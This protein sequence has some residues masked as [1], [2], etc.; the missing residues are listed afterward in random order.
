[1]ACDHARKDCTAQ[2]WTGIGI[3]AASGALAGL[4]LG[5][6]LIAGAFASAA[7]GAVASVANGAATAAQDGRKYSGR[8]ALND[9]VTSGLFGMVGFG[10]GKAVSVA[11][12]ALFK[13]LAH[14]AEQ[15]RVAKV[16]KAA[17]EKPYT[18]N[19]DE[20]ACSSPG[21]AANT[22]AKTGQTVA[23]T[24]I[25]GNSA[26][27]SAKAYLYRLSDSE[28][29]Y[30]K[31]GISKDPG[32]RY[33]KSFMRDKDMEILQSGTRREM[34]NLER[35]IVERDPG[36]LNLEPWAGSFGWDVP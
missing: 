32:T 30:L 5:G 34:L 6:S 28:G 7:I 27:S 25:H 31:T 19:P 3:G 23:A 35:F 17:N 9:G 29:N 22:A 11:A 8:D 21:Q 13:R 18:G 24:A 16:W 26:T 1:M 33:P 15:A 10:V 36:P 20:I 2:I 4:T 14:I 12:K